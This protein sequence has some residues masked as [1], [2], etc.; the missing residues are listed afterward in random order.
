MQHLLTDSQ[1]QEFIINGYLS[2]QA[3]VE[4]GLH[5]Q[6]DAQL[7]FSIEHESWLGNN[8]AARI[9]QLHQI[10]RCPVVNGAVQSL[11][12]ENFYCHPHRAIHR[13][14]PTGSSTLDITAD[15]EAPTMGRGSSAGSAWHQD[16]QSPLARARHHLPRY[17]IGFYFP[18]TTPRAMGPTRLQA[19]SYLHARPHAPSGV[20]MPEL[21]EAGTFMLVHFDMLHA[22]FPNGAERDRLMIKFVFTR[23][24]DFAPS[25]AHRST[26]WQTPDTAMPAWGCK[27][28][29]AYLWARVC[30]TTPEPIEH[31]PA[32]GQDESLLRLER[33][34]HTLSLETAL[35]ELC[36]SAGQGRHTRLLVRDKQGHERPRD[37]VRDYPIR[38]NE[39][40]IVMED[41]TYALVR[42][43]APAVPELQA[44]LAAEDPWIQINAAFALA[45][46]GV[47]DQGLHKLLESSTQQVV[48]Q[49]LDALGIVGQPADLPVITPLLQ[50][51]QPAWERSE[52]ERGWTAADQ[53]RLNAAFAILNIVSRHGPDPELSAS[54]LAPLSQALEDTNGYVAAVAAET[55]VRLQQPDS[56]A[57]AVQYLSD[58]RWDDTLQGH[59][60]AY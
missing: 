36:A 6:I 32:S 21:V 44:L 48:R 20:V 41:A 17:L 52:V 22:G 34:Y 39:R 11:L 23:T 13:S 14:T 43:G 16:A 60:K 38:W 42:I 47:R 7:R 12:G 18:H 2:L 30:G 37:D 35:A 27:A 29:H 59:L 53:V 8:V 40:A 28:A 25:W 54:L 49:S 50:A 5:D 51:S 58:R 15:T 45:E 9:P 3:D 46:M 56:I 10:V 26:D 33:I 57:A 19:G 31:P 4:P 1:V 55:L 24:A